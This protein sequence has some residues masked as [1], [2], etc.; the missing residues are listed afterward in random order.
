MEPSVVLVLKM[1]WKSDT[2]CFED[3]EVG[4]S[5]K[6]FGSAKA[7]AKFTVCRS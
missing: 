5:T 7:W 2:T 1:A 3:L 6:V 4:L